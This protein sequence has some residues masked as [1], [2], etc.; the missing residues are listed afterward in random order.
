MIGQ[1]DQ[2]AVQGDWSKEIMSA[3]SE[4]KI[5][6]NFTVKLRHTRCNKQKT[7]DIFLELLRSKSTYD[8]DYKQL[9]PAISII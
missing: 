3:P 5:L 2:Q 8:P 7:S 6:R 4:P 9:L 1:G